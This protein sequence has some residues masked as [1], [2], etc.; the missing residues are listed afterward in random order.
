MAAASVDDDAVPDLE[1]LKLAYGAKWQEIAQSHGL[2]ERE[3]EISVL[4]IEGLS[5]SS[6]AKRLFIS[7]S[8]VRF[9]LQ[10]VYRKFGVHSRQ[11]LISITE[12]LSG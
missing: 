1:T 6:I 11:D 5:A 4:F 10:N 2:S 8:T 12:A 3:I 7:E 9:H